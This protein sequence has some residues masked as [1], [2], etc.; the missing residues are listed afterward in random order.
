MSQESPSP[1]Q[2][3]PPRRSSGIWIGLLL[4]IVAAGAV[5]IYF[6]YENKTVATAANAPPPAPPVTVSPPVRREITEWNEY[7]GQFAATEFVELRARVSGYLTEIHFQDGQFVNK[8]DLL[9]VIDPRPFEI[10]LASA[11]AQL[12]Q[13]TA[14]LELGNRQLSRAA[15]LRL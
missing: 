8:G 9:F 11:K 6:R 1:S 7:T 12:A 3:A 13:A 10:A 2:P 15:E 14:R 5:A 4:L